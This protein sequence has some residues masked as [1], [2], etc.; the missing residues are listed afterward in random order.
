MN[1]GLRLIE[2]V[3]RPFVGREEEATLVTVTVLSLGHCVLIGK[4]GTA[5]TAIIERLASL[6]GADFRKYQ[7]TKGTSL[8]DLFGYLDLKKF[9]E[10]EIE[11]VT[12]NTLI[13]AKIAFLDEIFDCSSSTLQALNSLLEGREVPLFYDKYEVPLLSLFGASNRVPEDPSLLAFYDRFMVKHF[14]NPVAPEM[15]AEGLRRNILSMPLE[16]DGNDEY[17]EEEYVKML[18]RRGRDSAKYKVADVVRFFNEVSRFMVRN[19]DAISELTSRVV[20]KLREAGIEVSDRMAMSPFHFPRLF[21]THSFVF[22]TSLRLSAMRMAKYLV[23]YPELLGRYEE[24]IASLYPQ[25]LGE[26]ERKLKEAQGLMENGNLNAAEERVKQARQLL[27]SI[28][29][30]PEFLESYNEEVSELTASCDGILRYIAEKKAELRA[31][32]RRGAK[33]A[34]TT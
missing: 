24:A 2:D 19:V 15:I 1:L 11:R 22:G 5:K 27:A 34:T 12:K 18:R 32:L 8:D 20:L 25:E 6:I 23:P 10:G 14:V 29:E 21:S 16:E 7:L 13:D 33:V 9:R 3:K 30:R 4:P 31:E 26:A 28:S 17:F